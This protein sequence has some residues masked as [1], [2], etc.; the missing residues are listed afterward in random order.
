MSLNRGISSNGEIRMLRKVFSLAIISI[1]ILTACGTR[2]DVMASFQYT[3]ESIHK[4]NGRQGVCT[5]DGY[6]WVS[7]STSLTKYDEDWNVI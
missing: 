2:D 6:Y 1:L 4:V 5:E 7:G 3:L